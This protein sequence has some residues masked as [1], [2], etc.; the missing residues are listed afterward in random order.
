[1]EAHPDANLK[2]IAE[3]RLSFIFSAEA[4]AKAQVM[5]KKEHILQR[6]REQR[7][8]YRK[9]IKDIPKEKLAYI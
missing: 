1:M 3:F 7:G 4:A 6:A 8:T 9:K 5:Q 2:E